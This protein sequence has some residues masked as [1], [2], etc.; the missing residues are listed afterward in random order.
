MQTKKKTRKTVLA[1]ALLFFLFFASATLAKAGSLEIHYPHIPGVTT[2]QSVNTPFSIY[3]VYIYSF[4]VMIAGVLAFFLLVI[5]GTEY[6]FSGGKPA[7]LIDAKQ[8]ITGAIIGLLVVLSSYLILNTLNPQ[9]TFLRL[10]KAQQALPGKT[11][12][13]TA[14]VNSTSTYQE[15]PLGSLITSEIGPSTFFAT[16]SKATTSQYLTDFQGALYGKRLWRIHET[17]ST[18]V[19]VVKMIQK[20]YSEFLD[21]IEKL[22]QKDTE[23][24]DTL[25]DCKC[26]NCKK[27]SCAG[28]HTCSCNCHCSGN[29]CPSGTISKL[30]DLSKEIK[31][32]YEK[33]DSP[34]RCKMTELQYAIDSYKP[35]LDGSGR[36][37]RNKDHQD[38][39][40]WYSAE[41]KELRNKI[42]TCID[43]GN[44]DQDEFDDLE[45]LIWNST[46]SMAT[47]E[48]K[49]TYSPIT[50]P[51]ER[52]I[53]TSIKHLQNFLPD[54]SLGSLIIS[55]IGNL[56]GLNL[57][58]IGYLYK[59]KLALNPDISY[60]CFQSQPITFAQEAFLEEGRKKIRIIPFRVFETG[61]NFSNIISQITPTGK[62]LHVTEDPATF[63]CPYDTG[64]LSCENQTSNSITIHFKFNHIYDPHFPPP[65]TLWRGI[66]PLPLVPLKKEEG[67]YGEGEVIDKNLSP[68]TNY[69]YFLINGV[70]PTEPILSKINCKT[71]SKSS[72]LQKNFF[73]LFDQ[74]IA[75]AQDISNK[76]STP[77]PFIPCSHIVEIP[78]GKAL[79]EAIQLAS[80]ILRE[81]KNIKQQSN[82]IINQVDEAI[83]KD[84]LAEKMFKASNE[85]ID[86]RKEIPSCKDACMSKC[87]TKTYKVCKD[88]NGDGITDTCQD[89][90]KCDPGCVCKKSKTLENFRKEI[91]KI[92]SKIISNEGLIKANG[93]LIT[94]EVKSI[95][96]SFYKLNSKNTETGKPAPIG[97]DHCCKETNKPCRKLETA[98]NVR[99]LV[100]IPNQI[101]LKKYTL[102]EKL[103]EIQ[104]LLDLSRN[105]NDYAALIKGLIPLKLANKSEIDNISRDSRLNLSN[106]NV[107]LFQLEAMEAKKES[108]KLLEDCDMAKIFLNISPYTCSPDPPYNCDYFN[109]STTPKNITTR[110]NCYCYDEKI[111]PNL[112]NDYFCCEI[113]YEKQH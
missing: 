110:P 6:I 22:N 61:G 47:V 95:K 49:G 55:G 19:P 21:K 7:R 24:Y 60:G 90:C 16:S 8:R 33:D 27:G 59:A 32:L 63:Y 97:E 25:L 66:G 92:Y 31:S 81:L 91:S 54:T 41:A 70:L 43:K 44:I 39:S 9:L 108:A 67:A 111:Y 34:I 11:T 2:P 52:D 84:G 99:K 3:F 5:G 56:L 10:Q 40:Y 37:V 17:A 98:P 104:K 87:Q 80:D 35:F 62:K 88:T 58:K 14:I 79:D 73:R 48:N 42:K 82:S 20:I 64:A 36:L 107:Y 13:S 106:C 113:M 1:L 102:K 69:T 51:P 26:S 50:N 100:E 86:K 57:S 23:F 85:L 105:F 71:L 89:H 78:I 101:K 74:N 65:V 75:F 38:T 15:I 83:K 109:A 18:T 94:N 77:Q 93:S 76:S 112:S 12:G 30:N 72:F 53:G 29:I 46:S 68:N 96:E 103:A 45:K 4:L 28:D